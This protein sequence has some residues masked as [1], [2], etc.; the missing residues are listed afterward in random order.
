MTFHPTR[1]IQISESPFS[2]SGLEFGPEL[3]AEG[4]FRQMP[5]HAALTK[6]DQIGFPARLAIFDGVI[7][8]HELYERQNCASR[9]V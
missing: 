3:T 8:V 7:D 6:Y 5:D 1:N 2:V 4:L 9:T